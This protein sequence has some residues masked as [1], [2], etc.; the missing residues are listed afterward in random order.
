M[1]Q[2]AQQDQPPQCVRACQCSASLN[3]SCMR[4]AKTHGRVACP[5]EDSAFV[6]IAVALLDGGPGWSWI[7]K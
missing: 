5:T 4:S 2:R 6:G 3:Q 1:T 7:G